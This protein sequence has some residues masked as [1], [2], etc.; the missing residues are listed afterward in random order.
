M[1]DREELLRTAREKRET[2]ARVR[3]LAQGLSLNAD[4]ERL[5]RQAREIEVEAETLERQ[6]DPGT[7]P[8]GHHAPP[9]QQQQV[10]QQQQHETEAQPSDPKESGHKP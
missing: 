10:Q 3:R 1:A 9:V 8:A 2:A 6:A 5:M 7:P 4:H